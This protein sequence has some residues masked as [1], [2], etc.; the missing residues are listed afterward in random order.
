MMN[1]RER[2]L[3]AF[4]HE[5][6]DRVP[7][8]CQTTQEVFR[9]NCYEMWGD[10]YCEDP[11]F[12]LYRRNF[13]VLKKLGFD[14]AWGGG[15]PIRVPKDVL[16]D[17]PIPR[18][19][20]D[21][22]NLFVDLY[23][24]I[25]EREHL[26]WDFPYY[27]G[28]YLKTEE[29]YDEWMET[30]FSMPYDEFPDYVENTNKRLE[31]FK[32]D[33]FLPTQT[34]W[35]IFEPIWEGM[36]MALFAKIMRKKKHKLK[37]Y[38]RYLTKLAVQAAKIVVETNFEVFNL[39]DDTAFKHRTMMK[40]E[41]HKELIIPAYKEICQVIRKAG[42]Y[43]FFHSDGYTTPYFDGLIEAGFLGVESL[44]PN[45]GN[46]LKF[47]KEKFGD[48]LCLIGN[49]D[50]SHLLPFGT[51]VDV[52]TAVKKCIKDA[53]EGGGYILSPCTDLTNA[54]KVKNVQTMVAAT[55]KFGQYPLQF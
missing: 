27:C 48:E 44:E 12:I 18:L 40:P 33:E 15:V 8:F 7:L 2:V 17:N 31:K 16:K 26:G 45:A 28:T 14:S 30:Y 1:A 53:G 47:L 23:G 50:V 4:N 19:N 5:E 43:P 34:L 54:C 41:L 42:K 36:G 6:P 20:S 49:I 51:S 55:K 22:P 29:Q 39:C 32:T 46:D 35:S 9:K 52:V 3:K 21:N 37:K 10:D 13:N 25:Q 24:R 38:I 11:A